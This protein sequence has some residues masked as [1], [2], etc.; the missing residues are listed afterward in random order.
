MNTKTRSS[1]RRPAA[2]PAKEID[3]G[4]IEPTD[5][6]IAFAELGN[7]TSGGITDYTA[8]LI[9]CIRMIDRIEDAVSHGA[10]TSG[11]LVGIAIDRIL[12]PLTISRNELQKELIESISEG[13]MRQ[14]RQP[15]I[16]P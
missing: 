8:M 4:N 16:K 7:S 11:P 5:R 9:Q 1:P 13:A 2:R 12:D 15:A 14:S 3:P 6:T 10:E